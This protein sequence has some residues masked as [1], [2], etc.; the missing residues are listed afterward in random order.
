MIKTKILSLLSKITPENLAKAQ[1]QLGKT[2]DNISN[3][4]DS[5]NKSMDSVTKEL[6][7][8]FEKSNERRKVEEKKNQ[9]NLK[10]IFGDKK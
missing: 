8:D 3:G 1:E 7:S 9:E 4:I 10:K 5:F 2:F 6:S